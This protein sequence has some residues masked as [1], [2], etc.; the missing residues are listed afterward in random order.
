MDVP[1]PDFNEGR[2]E[3][4]EL[5][6]RLPASPGKDPCEALVDCFG[7]ALAK[8]TR[9]EIARLRTRLTSHFGEGHSFVEIT[10]GHIAL[11][12]ILET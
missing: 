9:D 11:R 6:G 1:L 5:Q 3:L 2:R 12:D 7:H 8:L 4:E 10:D